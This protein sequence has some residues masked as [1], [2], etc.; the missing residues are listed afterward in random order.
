MVGRW[1]ATGLGLALLAAG[2]AAPA[3]APDSPGGSQVPG[4]PGPPSPLSPP[5]P[6]AHP[7]APRVVGAA[8]AGRTITLAPGQRLQIEV[9]GV[10]T[11]GYLWRV[12]RID[13]GWQLVESSMRPENPAGRAAGMSGGQDWSVF[14]LEAPGP[15]RRSITLVYG[16]PWELDAGARPTETLTFT[17]VT[18]AN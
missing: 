7:V 12:G 16:R 1:M 15:S 17:A 13:A 6:P 5:A 11:A 8:D 3:A 14:V 4:P 10:P 2:C 9:I 18:S